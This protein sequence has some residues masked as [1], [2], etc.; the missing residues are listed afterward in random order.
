[1]TTADL[2]ARADGATSQPWR[3]TSLPAHERAE[4]LLAE[5][6]L[7]E[8]VGQLGSRRTRRP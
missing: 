6:T 7:A 1:V 2:G 3:D 8:K 5:L 4:L